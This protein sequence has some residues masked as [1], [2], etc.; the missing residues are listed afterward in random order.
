MLRALRRLFRPA[1]SME[2][3]VVLVAR[4][5]DGVSPDAGFELRDLFNRLEPDAWWFLNPGTFELLFASA[6]SG[7]SRA[8]KCRAALEQLGPKHP[9]LA[10]LRVGQAEGRLIVSRERGGGISAL[11]LGPAV[12]EALERAR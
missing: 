5:P 12:M 7:V 6:R 11:P 2:A 1:A 9:C 3:F 8:E 10:D 4:A